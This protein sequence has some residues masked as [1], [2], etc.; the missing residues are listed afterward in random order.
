MVVSSP[1]VSPCLLPILTCVLIC[2]SKQFVW[3]QSELGWGTNPT[4]FLLSFL[5]G[6]IFLNTLQPVPIP[7]VFLAQIRLWCEVG[8]SQREQSVKASTG[9]ERG[10]CKNTPCFGA[11][12]QETGCNWLHQAMWLHVVAFAQSR[13]PDLSACGPSFGSFSFCSGFNRNFTASEL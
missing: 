12:E 9:A 5:G 2:L 3:L 13:G 11:E 8:I 1:T 7:A 6:V 4:L 10:V